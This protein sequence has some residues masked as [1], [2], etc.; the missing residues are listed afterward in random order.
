MVVEILKGKE[1]NRTE[2]N[3]QVKMGWDVVG[4][5]GNWRIMVL[6]SDYLS[7]QLVLLL[8]NYVAL[9]SWLTSVGS[10]FSSIKQR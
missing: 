10:V 2:G 5:Y 7:F 4:G 6:E 1:K 9:A 8:S 3:I